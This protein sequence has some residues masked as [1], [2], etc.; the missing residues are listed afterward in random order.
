MKEF[1]SGEQYFYE[2]LA[3]GLFVDTGRRVY[4]GLI[5]APV[6]ALKHDDHVPRTRTRQVCSL[7][8]P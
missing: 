8:R 3:T 5:S 7:L 2:L 4:K 6:W 1:G